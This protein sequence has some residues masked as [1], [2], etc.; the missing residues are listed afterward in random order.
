MN[1][2][3]SNL[4]TYLLSP[5]IDSKSTRDLKKFAEDIM[6]LEDFKDDEIQLV[7]C[8]DCKI[9]SNGLRLM[10]TI[11]ETKRMTKAII[12]SNS[13]SYGQ[14]SPSENKMYI[15]LDAAARKSGLRIIKF[16]ITN[17]KFTTKSSEEKFKIAC[18]NILATMYHEKRHSYQHSLKNNSF[19]S[20]MYSMEQ[21]CLSL[22]REAQKYY[23]SN[24]DNWFIEIDANKV[25]INEAFKYVEKTN[26]ERIDKRLLAKAK[27]RNNV[28]NK[29]YDFDSVFSYFNNLLKNK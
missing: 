24:H 8:K 15:L 14:Y 17:H 4:I 22:S 12:K 20:T 23:I 11:E 18:T 13:K 16:D 25:G 10:D 7:K 9:L 6:G 3:K 5:L 19:L 28:L 21:A 2:I 27:K 26:D 1:K 29:L